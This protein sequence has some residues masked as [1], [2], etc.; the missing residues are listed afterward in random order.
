M[1]KLRKPLLI[2]LLIFLVS[3]TFAPESALTADDNDLNPGE[4]F[5]EAVNYYF[6]KD[7][8]NAAEGFAELLKINDLD[9]QIRTDALYYSALTAVKNYD[10]GTALSNLRELEEINYQ[11]GR[12]YWEI[13]Q[14]FLNKD[15]KFDSADFERA[16]EYLEKASELGL[17]RR[18]FKR[19]YAY[20]YR[21]SGELDQAEKIYQEILNDDPG[22][23]DY[24]NIAGIMEKKGELN[25][26]V[27]YYE[28]A[29]ESDISSGSVYFNLA[30]LYQKLDRYNSAVDIYKQGIEMNSDFTPY[31]IG[32]A[33]SYLALE[34]YSRAENSLQKAV[35][36]NPKGYYS[37]YLLGIVNKE[38]GNYSQAFNYLRESL[39]NNPDYVKA[40]LAEG[41]IHLDN[42]DYYRAISRFT[43]AVEKNELYA[44]S[45]YYLG[46]A[47]YRA[48]MYDAARAELRKALHIDDTYT[49]A[50]ELLDI[51]EAR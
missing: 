4:L 48:E 11:S 27:E 22:P 23:Q 32:L 18:A 37:Y 29:L 43:L 36:L 16:L 19:D 13:A 6:Q 31:H 5:S 34:N 7:Y 15:G 14:L 17:S 35:E 33:E 45:R 39:K 25:K 8:N 41:Q 28:T 3:L 21:E 40:Y 20:A 9:E 10:T 24:V 51:I 1:F 42:G 38:R 2:F 44:E 26:A 46:L 50:R 30:E 12:L 47:Y 49:E